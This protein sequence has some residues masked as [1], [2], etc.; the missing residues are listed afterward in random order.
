MPR[1][2]VDKWVLVRR[3]FE[4]VGTGGFVEYEDVVASTYTEPEGEGNPESQ[5][6]G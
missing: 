1:V 3:D 4:N 6:L 5:D 2:L